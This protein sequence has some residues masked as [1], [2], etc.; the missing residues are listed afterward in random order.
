MLPM[1]TTIMTLANSGGPQ[2]G[3]LRSKKK[4]EKDE[5]SINKGKDAE[6]GK[7]P[8]RKHAYLYKEM[9]N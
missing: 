1:Y 9:E 2:L 4:K 5:R 3:P 6:G 8:K 7:Q